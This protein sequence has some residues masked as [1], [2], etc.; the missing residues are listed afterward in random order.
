M[1]KKD[2]VTFDYWKKNKKNKKQEH[3]NLFLQARKEFNQAHVFSEMEN[4][5]PNTYIFLLKKTAS[6]KA[7]EPKMPFKKLASQK[8]LFKMRS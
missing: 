7:M 4:R 3:E 5:L 8:A 1:I 2:S 6:K